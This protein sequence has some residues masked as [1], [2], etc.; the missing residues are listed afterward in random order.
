M[1]IINKKIN[2]LIFITKGQI[3]NLIKE[4]GNII[5]DQK[6][7]NKDKNKNNIKNQLIQYNNN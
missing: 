5:K 7:L 2:D 1:K 3:L 6:I 4:I